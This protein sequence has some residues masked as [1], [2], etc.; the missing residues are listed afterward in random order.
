MATAAKNIVVIQGTDR[1]TTQRLLVEA[2]AEWRV[3]GVKAVGVTAH[4]H[5][6][7]DRKCTAGVLRDIGSGDQF[8]IYLETPPSDVSCDLDAGGVSAACA[9]VMDQIT[10]GD[11]V[12][13][14]KFGKLEAMKRGLFPAFEAAV[15]TGRPIVTTVSPKHLEAWRAFAPNATYIDAEMGALTAWLSPI[16]PMSGLRRE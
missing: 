7:P 6:A 10:A 5:G 14:S 3:N 9:V 13:L 8:Q 12:V 15:A 16:L 1:E 2:A 4:G 11:I